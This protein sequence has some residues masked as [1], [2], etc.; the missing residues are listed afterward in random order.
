MSAREL[1]QGIVSVVA[2]ECG[3]NDCEEELEE[4]LKATFDID[5][6]KCKVITDY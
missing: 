5:D 2:E 6:H 3:L 1:G 4:N